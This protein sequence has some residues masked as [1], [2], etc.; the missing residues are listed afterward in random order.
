MATGDL[1][2]NVKQLLQELKTVKYGKRLDT[3]E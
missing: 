2:N 3:E 1:K